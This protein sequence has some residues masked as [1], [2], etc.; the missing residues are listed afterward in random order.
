MLSSEGL[1][2][3]E[4]IDKEIILKAFKRFL[5]ENLEETSSKTTDKTTEITKAFLM[6]VGLS[7]R[8]NSVDLR[9]KLLKRLDIP[10]AVA[11]NT[12]VKVLN[13]ITTKEEIIEILE[14]IN[15]VE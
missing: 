15:G 13:D 10:L 5:P 14:E 12:L 8:E 3:V 11:P 1:L 6:S 4:G 2:G 7:G 9:K